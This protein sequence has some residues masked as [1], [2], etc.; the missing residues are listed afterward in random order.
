MTTTTQK[1]LRMQ[2]VQVRLIALQARGLLLPQQ[3]AAQT[4]AG[5][6]LIWIILAL[7]KTHYL[8]KCCCTQLR[9]QT[10]TNA[11]KSLMEQAGAL[12]TAI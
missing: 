8:I 4:T 10:I 5:R 7:Q 11:L 1:C 12:G 6:L 9:R 2:L 3:R